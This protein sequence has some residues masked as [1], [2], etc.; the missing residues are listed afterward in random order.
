MLDRERN[1]DLNYVL[2]RGRCITPCRHARSAKDKTSTVPY[3]GKP[4]LHVAA[5]RDLILH[6]DVS[7]DGPGIALIV[8]GLCSQVI[9]TFSLLFWALAVFLSLCFI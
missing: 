9:R 5:T 6:L 8:P 7:E 3:L 2:A 1:V 4:C